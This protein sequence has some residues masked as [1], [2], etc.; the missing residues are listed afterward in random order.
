M[1]ARGTLYIEATPEPAIVAQ[2]F[3]AAAEKIQRME[4]PL[5]AAAKLAD[6][7]VAENFASQGRP[8]GWE[9]LS[10]ATLARRVYFSLS[11]SQREKLISMKQGQKTEGTLVQDA[12]G[13]MTFVAVAL[14]KYAQVFAGLA[15]GIQILVDSGDLKQLATGGSNWTY[16][17]LSGTEQAMEMG[18]PTGYG[19]YH[20]TGTNKMPARDWSYISSEAVDEMASYMAD[21]ATS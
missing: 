1:P 2:A 18:D 6:S 3:F 12:G 5:Q 7:E 19:A 13:N 10:E 20:I 14:T 4:E 9:P 15:S 16:R 17:H 11:P 8:T 21:W